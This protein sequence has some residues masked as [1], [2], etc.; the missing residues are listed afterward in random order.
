MRPDEM[1]RH[2]AAL[3]ERVRREV[4][5]SVRLDLLLRRQRRSRVVGFA[6]AAVAVLVLV[7]GTLWLTGVEDSP[8][9]DQPPTPAPSTTIDQRSLPVEVY[10]ALLD[11]FVV[12]SEALAHCTGTGIHAGIGVGSEVSVIDDRPDQAP[13]V[14]AEAVIG[15]TG[16]LI[17]AARVDQL[18]LPA[19]QSACLF[20]VTTIPVAVEEVGSLRIGGES[21]PPPGGFEAGASRAGQ[22]FVFYS[23]GASP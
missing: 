10:I 17:D 9:V 15:D 13:R 18:G 12:E 5:T 20:E 21:W 4:D 6:A 2:G 19:G 22:Q 11:E 7:V 1:R 8:V 14:V 3:A 16:A 23:R